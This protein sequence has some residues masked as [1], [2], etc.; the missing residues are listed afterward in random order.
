MGTVRSSPLISLWK[1]SHE[2]VQMTQKEMDKIA[3][4]IDL[5]LP[6]SGEWTEGMT[7]EDEASYI[8]VY[9]KRLDWEKQEAANI[10]EYIDD[11]TACESNRISAGC[12]M[13]LTLPS[14]GLHDLMATLADISGYELADDDQALD[15]ISMLPLLRDAKAA[16]TTSR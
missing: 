10:Q 13:G 11:L 6:H 8:R 3:C 12:T 1:S 4:W 5:A 2:D 14:V 16:Y 9:Q 7:P 15:S